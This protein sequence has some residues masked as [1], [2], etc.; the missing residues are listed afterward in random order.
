MHHSFPLFRHLQLDALLPCL[1]LHTQ[2]SR[3]SEPLKTEIAQFFPAE[4]PPVLF[5]HTYY[6][7]P[8][9]QQDLPGLHDLPLSSPLIP[10]LLHILLSP[11]GLLLVV[12]HPHLVPPAGLLL[13]LL[14]PPPGPSQD[15]L[16]ISFRALFRYHLPGSLASL[17]VLSP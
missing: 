11:P 10:P 16:L 8:A 9:S 2:N 4:N 6:K 12:K 13:G 15:P 3:E 14:L 1:V 17:T 7:I 5:H